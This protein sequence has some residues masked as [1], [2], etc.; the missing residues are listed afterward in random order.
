MIVGLALK[1]DLSGFLSWM[2][3]RLLVLHLVLL[4]FYYRV[5]ISTILTVPHHHA[6][7]LLPRQVAKV[8]SALWMQP[9]SIWAL[10]IGLT[11]HEVASQRFESETKPNT[12]TELIV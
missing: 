2:F 6:I 1:L 8:I 7:D 4:C 11:G 5:F 3:I 9:A 12:P 10:I